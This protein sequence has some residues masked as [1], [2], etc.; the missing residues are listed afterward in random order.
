MKRLLAFTTTLDRDAV[1]RTLR[2]NT[3]PT[4]TGFLTLLFDKHYFSGEVNDTKIR[5][6]NA[7]RRPNNP[8]PILNITITEKSEVTEIIILDDTEDDVRANKLLI[9]TLTLSIAVLILLIG[10]I[11]SFVIPGQYSLLSTLVISIVVLGFG[12]IN[13]YYHKETL[14]QNKRGDLDFLLRL[15][16]R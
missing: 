16:K 7:S 13:A 5:L 15:L 8:S 12:F 4:E 11:L 3:Y 10:G 1:I 14:T 9:Q 6:K 2:E